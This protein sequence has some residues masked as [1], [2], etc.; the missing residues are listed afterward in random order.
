M[1]NLGNEKLLGG[2]QLMDTAVKSFKRAFPGWDV[3]ITRYCPDQYPFLS[4][5]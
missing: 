4:K 3:E 2:D 1:E 5:A